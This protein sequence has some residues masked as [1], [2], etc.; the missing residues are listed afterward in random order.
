VLTLPS[1]ELSGKYLTQTV[2]ILRLWSTKLGKYDGR[3]PEER[4]FVDVHLNLLAGRNLLT[5]TLFSAR[6]EHC[7]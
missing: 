6:C 2:A 7:R 3:T 4:Y 1:V 5:H